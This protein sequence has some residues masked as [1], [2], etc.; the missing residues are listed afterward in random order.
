VIALKVA[1]VCADD[2]LRMPVARAFDAAPLEWEITICDRPPETAD[3]VVS[4]GAQIPGAVP[5]DPDHPER[6]LK[7]IEERGRRCSRRV[8]SIFGATGGCGATTIALHLA[9]RVKGS[10]CLLVAD[11]ISAALRLGLEPDEIGDEPIPV[12][13]DFRV[14]R[15]CRADPLGSLGG[16]SGGF[17]VLLVDAGRA[18]SETVVEGS[19]LSVVVLPPSVPGG[20]SALRW[21]THFPHQPSALVVNRLG[22]GGEMRSKDLERL[23][24]RR[25][26]IELPCV[27]RLRDV[28]DDG[29]LL[30]GWSLWNLRLA[31]LARALH[32]G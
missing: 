17:E 3:V 23:I 27:R 5:F 15:L 32:L 16:A 4:A 29:R 25:V 18:W 20:R 31:A 19:A 24:G 10:V 13:G 26:A 2:H 30:E 6:L 21:V 8:I 28:E 7:D 14:A 22:P 12:P 11:E 9:A 1:V